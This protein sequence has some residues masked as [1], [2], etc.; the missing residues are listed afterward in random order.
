MLRNCLQEEGLSRE[1]LFKQVNILSVY[2]HLA[3]SKIIAV[4]LFSN[5]EI[6]K[7]EWNRH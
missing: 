4:I 5:I 6:V 2:N 1:D 7:N 3:K